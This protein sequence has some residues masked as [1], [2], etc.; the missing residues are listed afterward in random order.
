LPFAFRG[1]EN[2]R[3]IQNIGDMLFVPRWASSWDL[4][5]S[6][7]LLVGA[8]AALGPNASGQGGE[9]RTE[10]Y[11]LDL[12]WKWK[13][14]R[15]VAGYP[16]VTFTTEALLRRYD[17]GSYDWNLNGDGLND[18]GELI[19]PAT[20]LPAVLGEE[21]LQDYGFYT[22]VQYGFR[23]NWVA[24][25]RFDYVAGDTGDYEQLG[26]I[27]ADGGGGL[28]GTPA[29]QD[30]LRARRWRVSPNLTWFPTEFS[31]LRLQYNYDDRESVGVDHSVW[32]QFEFVLGAH[33]AHNF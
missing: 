14:P 15:H 24:A 28:S 5:S 12:T 30:L 17:V 10:V 33:G 13:S 26:L 23:R 3:G 9:T 19:D 22:Q 18:A 2:D 11:G 8:S 20:G 1:A 16:F 7:T 29:G 6:Q 25:L 32:F 21:T 27:V 4:T 31:K